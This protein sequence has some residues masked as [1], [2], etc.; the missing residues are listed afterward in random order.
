M[1]P[2]K[3]I[4]TKNEDPWD[5]YLPKPVMLN[6]KIQ[7]HIIEQKRPPLIKANNATVPVENS[8][9]S[10]AVNPIILNILSVAIALSLAIKN[11]IIWIA[12]I[13]EN[14]IISFQL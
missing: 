8:P 6:E 9:I 5:V 10:I 11:P 4:I 7:G 1:A 14:I 12:T 13:T 3:I 2:P